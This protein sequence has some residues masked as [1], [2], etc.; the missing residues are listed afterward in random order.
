MSLHLDTRQRAMLA[1]MGIKLWARPGAPATSA[2]E[3]ATASAA[4]AAIESE[5]ANADLARA[6]GDQSARCNPRYK[7]FI[8]YI[9]LDRRATPALM[10]FQEVTYSGAPLSDHCA[11][12]ARL[13]AR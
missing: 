4:N 10:Q 9:V 11:I 6:S 2:A 12:R 7:D 3:S 5:A 1:E 13:D 8:D